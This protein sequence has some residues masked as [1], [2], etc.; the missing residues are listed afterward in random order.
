MKK[1]ESY[2]YRGF[3]VEVY[4]RYGQTTLYREKAVFV[5]VSAKGSTKTFRRDDCVRE[6]FL[7]RLFR[8]KVDKK[9]DILKYDIESRI[10]RYFHESEMTD[11][12]LDS[13]N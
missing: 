1:I 8:K 6:P 11:G 10:D 9:I 2:D 4:A 13:I 7:T 3:N 12:L 5:E